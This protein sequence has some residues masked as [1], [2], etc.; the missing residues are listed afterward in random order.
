MEG[1]IKATQ[2]QVFY[3]NKP[4]DDFFSRETGRMI[5]RQPLELTDNLTTFDIKV[6]IK[7]FFKYSSLY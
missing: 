7:N 6:N 4:V 2:G 5:V 1:I 3:N